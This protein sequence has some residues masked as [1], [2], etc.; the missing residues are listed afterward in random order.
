MA[1]TSRNPDEII[2]PGRFSYNFNWNKGL[3]LKMPAIILAAIIILFNIFYTIQPNEVGVVLRFGKFTATTEP[4]LHIKI[5]FGIDKVYPVKVEFVY[6]EEFGFRT[7]LPGVRTQHSRRDYSNESLMLSGD[8]NVLDVEWIVQYKISDPFAVLFQMRDVRKTLRDISESVMRK[9][10]GDYT[11]DEIL[12]TKRAEINDLAQQN[13]QNILDSYGIGITIITVKLQDVNPPLPVQGAF[14]EVNEAKQ[15]REKLINEA[16]EI[17]NR[18]IPQAKGQALKIIK[19][20]EGYKLERINTA[21]GDA[22][23]FL[24]LLKEYNQAKDV[25]KQRLYLENMNSILT[26]AGKK[27][28]VDPEQKSILPLLQLGEDE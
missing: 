25:T 10:S 19:E 13:M 11:F 16:W 7:T 5:P 12:T 23:R 14:N 18:K 15:E 6:K 2:P 4:G 20:A 27:Y 9:I 26:K 17:Y 24:L 1:F 22:K 21:Q 28:I 3:P 8:L